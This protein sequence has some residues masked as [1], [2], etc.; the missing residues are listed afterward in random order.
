[1]NCT[2][3]NQKISCGCQQARAS[4]GNLVHKGCKNTYEISIGNTPVPAIAIPITI[5]P[6]TAR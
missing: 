6:T 3:C 5:P 4:D 2:H 1:M